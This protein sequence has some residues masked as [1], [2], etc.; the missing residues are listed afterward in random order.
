MLPSFLASDYGFI[1]GQNKGFPFRSLCNLKLSHFHAA[2]EN[3][4]KD[5]SPFVRSAKFL[6]PLNIVL[7]PKRN[8]ENSG[9]IHTIVQGPLIK[10][11]KNDL[12]ETPEYMDLLH[13]MFIT[14]VLK[15]NKGLEAYEKYCEMTDS[16]LTYSS[17][18]LFKVKLVLQNTVI[19]FTKPNILIP[20][21]EDKKSHEINSNGDVCKAST[22][23]ST[24]PS[25]KNSDC[26]IQNELE[27]KK[28]NNRKC[29]TPEMMFLELQEWLDK[30]KTESTIG[31]GITFELNYLSGD[32][33]EW[34]GK[35]S[36]HGD[37]TR[38]SIEKFVESYK[39]NKRNL[40]PSHAEKKLSVKVSNT[41]GFYNH[42]I[43][44]K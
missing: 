12:G 44:S 25:P 11:V 20:I 22:S 24:S 10:L 42:K 14:E 28:N 23:T 38:D 43:I 13:Y 15:Y 30:R 26:C 7:T 33:K 2:A 5:V 8:R 31:Y 21:F 29:R 4:D 41:S 17:N 40:H 9:F 32:S 1:Q 16:P 37:S 19:R 3:I 39:L 18:D 6:S 34:N 27:H 35:Y 36:L